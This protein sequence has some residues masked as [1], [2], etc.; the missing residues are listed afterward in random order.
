M[1]FSVHSYIHISMFT[2]PSLSSCSFD[3][4]ILSYYPIMVNFYRLEANWALLRGNKK[5]WTKKRIHS[6]TY[7]YKIHMLLIYTIQKTLHTTHNTHKPIKHHV[8]TPHSEH[9][10]H[11]THTRNLHIH[12]IGLTLTYDIWY[13]TNTQFS[14]TINVPFTNC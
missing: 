1:L 3:L 14:H 2:H 13:R 7:T 9:I 11:A 10:Y 8:Q 5:N 6:T 12:P 4:F